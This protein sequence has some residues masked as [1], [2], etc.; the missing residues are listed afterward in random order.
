MV[1]ETIPLTPSDSMDLMGFLILPEAAVLYSHINLPATSILKKTQLNQLQFN[2]WSALTR[3]TPVN[4]KTIVENQD[5]NIHFWQE[6]EFLGGLQALLFAQMQN[7]DDRRPDTLRKFLNVM[8]PKTRILFDLIKKYIRKNTSY[9]AII[10]YL[11]PFSIYPDDI[12]FKQYQNI[13]SFMNTNILT[14]KKMLVERANIYKSYIHD[15]V[16]SAFKNSYLFTTLH[17]HYVRNYVEAIL[18]I[19][20]LR[21]ATTAE[22]IKTIITRDDGR[23][24]TSAL[25]WGEWDLFLPV[26]IDQLIQRQTEKI[27]GPLEDQPESLPEECKNFVLAKFYLDIADLREDDNTTEVYFDTKYDETRYEIIQEFSSEQASMEPAQFNDFLVKHLVENAGLSE[28]LATRETAAM[29]AGKRRVQENDYAYIVNDDYQNM[30]YVRQRDQWVHI[31]DLNGQKLNKSLFCNLQTPCVSIKKECGNMQINTRKIKTQLFEQIMAQYN[32][33]HHI[34]SEDLFDQ[35]KTQF[36]YHL[37]NSKRLQTVRW[38]NIIFYDQKHIYI[39][40]LLGERDIIVSPNALLRDLIL[41]QNDFVKKQGDIIKFV[42]EKCRSPA[43]DS[44]EDMYWFYCL[45]TNQRLLPSFFKTL[46]DAYYASSYELTLSKVVAERG[47]ISDDGDKIV[48]KHS[49]YTI[50]MIEYDEGEGYD[51]S[52][53]KIVSREIL[54]EDIGDILMDM[55]FKPVAAPVSEREQMIQN[56]ITTMERSLHI[57]IG[58]ENAFVIKNTMDKLVHYLPSEAH[59][60]ILQDRAKQKQ[61]RMGSYKDVVDEALLYFTL[62]YFLIAIQTAMPSLRTHKTFPGCTRAFKGYPLGGGTDLGAITYIMCVALR[63]RSKT[64]PWQRLP[65]T[66][67]SNQVAIIGKLVAKM[68]T[69]IETQLLTESRIKAKITAKQRYLLEEVPTETIAPAFDVKLWLTFLPPLYPIRITALQQLPK[70]FENNLIADVEKGS[71]AQFGKLEALLGRSIYY[72]LHIQELIQR[73]INKETLLLE[74]LQNELLIE[75]ACC[76]TGS[77]NTIHYFIDKEANIVTYNTRIVKLEKMYRSITALTRPA[78]IFNPR[79]TKLIYPLLLKEFSKKTIY[80]GFIRFCL[81]NTGMPLDEDIQKVC[82]RNASEFKKSDSIQTK[83]AIMKREGR[84]YSPAHFRELMTLINRKN[85]VPFSLVPNLLTRRFIFEQKLKN[86]SFLTRIQ[87]TEL[88]TFVQM[89]TDYLDTF[90]ILISPG[91]EGSSGRDSIDNITI[92]LDTTTAKMLEQT[93]LPFLHKGQDAETAVRFLQDLQEWK[94]RG[95]NIYM[96]RED[97]TAVMI[98]NYIEIN[99]M[100]IMHIYPMMVINS[101]RHD[102]VNL[103]SEWKISAV[104]IRDIQHIIQEEHH[105]LYRFYDDQTIIPILQEVENTSQDLLDLLYLLPF[106]SDLR[107]EG[108]AERRKTILNGRLMRKILRFLLIYTL[109][110][111]I[112]ITRQHETVPEVAADLAVAVEKEILQGRR[113]A[114]EQKIAGLLNAYLLMMA[115]QKRAINISNQEITRDILKSKEKEKVKITKRLGEL[116]QDSRNVEIIM[117]NHRLGKWNL[118]QTRALYE[119]DEEQYDKERASIEEDA[120]VEMRLHNVD[121]VTERTRQIYKIA[122]MED[123]YEADLQ[124]A[125]SNAVLRALPDDDDFGDRDGDDY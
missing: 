14:L 34:S 93:V 103:P 8:I 88:N 119:Y 80:T 94:L 37:V 59:Y 50:R 87:D 47:E 41:S 46:A 52:G 112:K 73:V 23:L 55:S 110:T 12:S 64:R 21:K 53:Y 54:E 70:T 35:L 60:K 31:P 39:G 61:R 69:L 65:R 22:F 98:R 42:A 109:T 111:Y 124:A 117:K 71:D 125:E 68:R 85:I 82:G 32:E 105:Q 123:K 97:E 3:S 78:V 79:D 15:H 11:E 16:S 95:E 115:Q 19:Y 114:T 13:V 45:D 4:I 83:I 18:E 122:T 43:V 108:E 84:H 90:K 74:N 20:S 91:K 106:F 92:F 77:R 63:L 33:E 26:P 96:S 99:I 100:N 49:G 66:N 118:G 75:N 57:S 25:A 40:T 67:R 5:S 28:V 7:F 76:N 113:E 27:L 116:T 81:Y 24:Y 1:A 72:A 62:A 29:I 104:H 38:E 9:L 120:L 36:T 2:Y 86:T 56:I 58:S 17:S 89:M 44:D 48:D 121:G 102:H 107:M 10:E 6:G 51:E 30:Y 101:V